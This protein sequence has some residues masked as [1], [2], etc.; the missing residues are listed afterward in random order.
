MKTQE[1]VTSVL[2]MAARQRDEDDV[3]VIVT[4]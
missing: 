1:D 3:S 2:A 4:L